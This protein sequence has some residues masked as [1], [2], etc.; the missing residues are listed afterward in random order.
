MQLLMLCQRHK[1]CRDLFGL[2][3]RIGVTAPAT[4]ACHVSQGTVSKVLEYCL[5]SARTENALI[6]SQ[7]SRHVVRLE[8]PPAR[9]LHQSEQTLMICGSMTVRI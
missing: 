5:M 9:L 4:A 1:S 2:N 8:H 6:W 7:G 3:A